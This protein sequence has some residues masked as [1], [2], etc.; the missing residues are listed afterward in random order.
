M[1][2]IE[3]PMCPVSDLIA[4]RTGRWKLPHF[5]KAIRDVVTQAIAQ[6]AVFVFLGHPSCL[7]VTNPQFQTV[8][9]ICDLVNQSQSQSQAQI[10]DLES[11]AQGVKKAQRQ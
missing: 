4:F 1:G 5:L 3:I 11:I 10:V 9:L 2:L 6:R 8:E 7:S